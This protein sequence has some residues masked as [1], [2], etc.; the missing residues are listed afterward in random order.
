[1]NKIILV[2]AV[3]LTIISCSPE[4]NNS[5]DCGTI[6]RVNRVGNDYFLERINNC[7]HDPEILEITATEWANLQLAGM[8]QQ[9]CN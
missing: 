2:F 9:Y 8:G 3:I 7:S 6:V 1:M 4:D 5:C